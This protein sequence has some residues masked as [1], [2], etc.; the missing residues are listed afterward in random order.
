MNVANKRKQGLNVSTQ[1]SFNLLK[2]KYI[3]LELQI[4]MIDRPVIK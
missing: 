4:R 3:Q 1:V 2:M